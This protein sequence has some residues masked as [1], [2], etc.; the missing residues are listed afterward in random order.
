MIR[1]GHKG[2]DA[3]RPGNTLPSFVAAAMA[4]A[5]VIEL[6]VLRPESDFADGGDWRRAPAG[7]ARASG[8]LLV[9]HDWGDARRR[10][11]M[12][13]TEALDALARPPLAEV[14]IDLDLKLAGREDEI[15]ASLRQH[16][17]L[18]RAMVSTMETHSLAFLREHEPS[19]RRG[20]TL[21]KVR[22]DWTR[23]RWG[24]PVVVAGSASLRARLPGII[25]RRAPRLGV[26]AVWVYDSLITPRLIESAHRAGVRVIAWTVDDL[27]RMRA[28]AA[29]GV[30]GIC[31]ND[32]RLLSALERE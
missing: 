6:D 25:R 19:L 32:P 4:G 15:V 28:L 13:L 26:W 23:S 3:I 21:P 17:L 2:A 29:L 16:D 7:P 14:T 30:D 8:P 31:S 12:T 1:I 9:A 20:W 11:P 22:R 18:G 5:E 10:Q 24:R 27:D